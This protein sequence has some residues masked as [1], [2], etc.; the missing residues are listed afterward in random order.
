MIDR[1]PH[2][3]RSL[4]HKR[5]AE[6]SRSNR[7]KVA[8]AVAV[9]FG[10]G[11]FA[12]CSTDSTTNNREGSN[13]LA[14]ST[15]DRARTILD[16]PIALALSTSTPTPSPDSVFYGE[17]VL[18]N[19]AIPITPVFLSLDSYIRQTGDSYPCTGEGFVQFV[20]SNPL[21]QSHF[22]R[23]NAVSASLKEVKDLK[24]LDLIRNGSPVEMSYRTSYDGIGW[25]PFTTAL[26][27]DLGSA[28]F[29]VD[30]KFGVAKVTFKDGTTKEEPFRCD[31]GQPIRHKV[32]Q[33]PPVRIPAP[34]VKILATSTPTETPIIILPT[35]RP[36]VLATSTWTPVPQVP[37]LVVP[38]PAKIELPPAPIPVVPLIPAPR[39]E[40]PFIPVPI[41]EIPR[42][43]RPVPPPP[44]RVP[45]G[46]IVGFKHVDANGDGLFDNPGIDNQG[47]FS[48][49]A[50]LQSPLFGLPVR[51]EKYN[52]FG[53]FA[54]TQQYPCNLEYTIREV[55]TG[56]MQLVNFK[57]RGVTCTGD[58][59]E[60][61]NAVPHLPPVIIPFPT[62]TLPIIIL[63]PPHGGV[64]ETFTPLPTPTTRET[65]TPFVPQTAIS[66]NT[67]SRRESPSV[68]PF[69]PQPEIPTNTRSTTFPPTDTR[70]ATIIPHPTE[71]PRTVVIPHTRTS[72]PVPPARTATPFHPQPEIPTLPR[73]TA[74]PPTAPRAATI[75]PHPTETRRPAAVNQQP[76]NPN[77]LVPNQPANPNRQPAPTAMRPGGRIDYNSG[78]NGNPVFLFDQQTTLVGEQSTIVNADQIRNQDHLDALVGT[79]SIVGLTALALRNRIKKLFVR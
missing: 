44:G 22:Q 33:A 73:V 4:A 31:C 77:I 9:T 24:N 34:E 61:Y 28:R 79:I 18:D 37:E 23:E 52:G 12:S 41:P 68:T 57:G 65:A 50:L 47:N 63:T 10:I 16:E 46:P 30:E 19:G 32:V 51:L 26:Q 69:V 38:P 3:S 58:I 11:A 2:Y 17:I 5:E 39:Q 21:I 8:A 42:E 55:G 49:E 70:A 7:S 53:F 56:G 66:T 62:P 13:L 54:S 14:T 67:P 27:T 45:T 1:Q 40:I 75:V 64:P 60:F 36:V 78:E 29:A 35:R 71:T 74:A 20:S 72:I 6:K 59:P 43:Y 48:F 15:P 25:T 76:S